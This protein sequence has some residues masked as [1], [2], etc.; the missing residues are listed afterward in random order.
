MHAGTRGIEYE[1]YTVSQNAVSY[2]D[3]WKLN[4]TVTVDS[5][6]GSR[7][8]LQDKWEGSLSDYEI[9]SYCSRARAFFVAPVDGDYTFLL[10]ADDYGQLNGSYIVSVCVR[11][12]AWVCCNLNF[13]T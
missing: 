1:T 2:R 8:V 13:R 9:P 6:G 11:S 7:T 12:S 5:V 3:L 4:S 10:S